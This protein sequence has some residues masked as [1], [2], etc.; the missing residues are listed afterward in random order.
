MA[1]GCWT[2]KTEKEEGMDRAKGAS[3]KKVELR[4]R[5]KGRA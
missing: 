2:T 5:T 4:V 1:R 3:S